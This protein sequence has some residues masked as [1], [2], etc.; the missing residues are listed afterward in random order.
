MQQTIRLVL[1]IS[2]FKLVFQSFK[3]N[4][5]DEFKIPDRKSVKIL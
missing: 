5:C 2:T 4:C 3:E 1:L